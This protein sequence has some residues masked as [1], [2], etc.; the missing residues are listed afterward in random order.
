MTHPTKAIYR[1]LLHDFIRVSYARG[2]WLSLTYSAIDSED[3]LYDVKDLKE[4]LDRVEAVDFHSTIEVDGIR[5]TPYHAG[6][7]LGAA[8]YFIEIAGLK[9]FPP[10]S[11]PRALVNFQVLF[12]GDYSREDDRMLIP[13]ELPPQKPE[14]LICESTFGTAIHE[15]R[16]EKEARLTSFCP[17]NR[18]SLIQ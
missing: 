10:H 8:M 13:A 17:A 5:F 15:P 12:T 14:V 16:P 4:S 11:N 2:V 9:V 3:Q 1:S 7:V 6:H 18:P